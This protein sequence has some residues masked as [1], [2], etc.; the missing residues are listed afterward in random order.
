MF[1][2]S[3][4]TK[5]IKLHQKKYRDAFGMFLV[6]G[7]KGVEEAIA[8]KSHIEHIIFEEGRDVE[9][10][11]PN[12]TPVSYVSPKD[13]NKIKTT[14]TFPGVMAIVHKHPSQE[15]VEGPVICLDRINDPGNLGTI[16][17]TADWFGVTQI[18]LSEGSVDPYNPKVVRAT[19][20]SF[21]RTNI[22]E[23]TTIIAD[24]ETLQ[25][26]G[27]SLVSLDMHG[28]PLSELPKS[29]K[30]VYIFGSE[31]HGVHPE[32]RER[33]NAYTIPG[34]GHAE[35]LNVAMAAGIVLSHL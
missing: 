22:Q 23:S 4:K 1:E 28:A 17:R 30:T 15:F 21:F 10:T 20:G 26:K 14:E 2:K 7:K 16:I 6:E 33:S 27:Y 24:L 3:I 34:K 25:E 9:V 19:M 12:H 8:A 29:D 32:L 13:A 35:S 5:I 18:L 31:S 11:I